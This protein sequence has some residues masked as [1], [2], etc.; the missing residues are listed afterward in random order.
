[1]A[2]IDNQQSLSVNGDNKQ[3]QKPK[4]QWLRFTE[5]IIKDFANQTET[6]IPNDLEIEFEFFKSVDDSTQNST[7]TIKIKG[8]SEERCQSFSESGGEVILNCGYQGQISTLFRAYIMHI[9]SEISDNT[10]ITTIE[11]SM[12]LQEFYYS[13]SPSLV[14]N[15]VSS[16]DISLNMLLRNYAYSCGFADVKYYASNDLTEQEKKECEDIFNS[17]S[18][19]YEFVGTA[20]EALDGICRTFELIRETIISDSGSI[21]QLTASKKTLEFVRDNNFKRLSS[22]QVKKNATETMTFRTYY[23]AISN[24]ALNTA[25]I[26]S[27]ETGLLS[28]KIEYK[29]AKA[30]RDQQI[31]STDQE[32]FKSQQQTEKFISSEKKRKAK[33]D[34]KAKERKEKGLKELKPFKYKTVKNEIQVNRKYLKVVALLN[35]KVKPQSPVVVVKRGY[36]ETGVITEEAIVGRA[37]SVTYKGNN[38]SGDWSME[39][40]V[41][42]SP[43]ND[44]DLTPEQ[45]QQLKDAQSEGQ[46]YSKNPNQGG[47]SFSGGYRYNYQDNMTYD[48]VKY[49]GFRTPIQNSKGNHYEPLSGGHTKG[50]TLEFA[51]ILD[52]DGLGGK[53]GSFTAFND[54]YHIGRNS[55]H[56]TGKAVDLDLK[57]DDVNMFANVRQQIIDIGIRTGYNVKVI[58]EHPK[59]ASMGLT[60]FRWYP[61]S[62]GTHIHIEVLGRL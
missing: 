42:T 25:V 57:G 44:S 54:G 45:I 21:L 26:L 35:P 62:T 39:L 16:K 34:K 32:T 46:T 27:K 55:V 17:L 29:I 28:S 51:K 5:V 53:M 19:A 2:E 31:L 13:S 11:C 9:N 59:G 23:E 49:L 3:S 50:T 24:E 10:T 58:A 4:Y 37:R 43:E 1:M 6:K 61:H 60:G 33:Y 12:N 36:S 14:S 47:S 22:E 56:N 15:G 8:L 48:Q 30:Y 18:F 38:K 7:G 52:D 41:E 40:Y 20:D